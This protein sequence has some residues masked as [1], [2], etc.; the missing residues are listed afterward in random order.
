MM[1]TR[2][3]RFFEGHDFHE[4]CKFKD[5]HGRESSEENGLDSQVSAIIP[6]IEGFIGSR[7]TPTTTSD[8]SPAP[9]TADMLHSHSDPNHENNGIKRTRKR[10]IESSENDDQPKSTSGGSSRVIELM[11]M[12]ASAIVC[13]SQSQ[14]G[15]YG[16]HPKDNIINSV[17][18]DEI[19][20]CDASMDGEEEGIIPMENLKTEHSD[21][22][23]D[24]VR[25]KEL[26]P[27][28]GDHLPDCTEKDS[29]DVKSVESSYEF[30]GESIFFGTAM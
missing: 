26:T 6:N 7:N 19:S 12:C 25:M 28:A 15:R 27:P 14:A 3:L 5:V 21:D 17:T 2:L 10:A 9:P 20:E 16:P 18:K 24:E 23:Y 11:G 13:P 22:D 1:I 30:R 29:Q 4:F 8:I